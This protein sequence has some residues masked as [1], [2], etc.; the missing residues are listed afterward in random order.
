MTIPRFP[1]IRR[2]RPSALPGGLSLIE[3]TV[4]TLLA[5]TVLVS[6][7]RCV[8]AAVSSRVRTA[9]DVRAA[10]L[11]QQLMSE[12]VAQPYADT[13]DLVRVFGL[14]LS[15]VYAANGPRLAF[16][17]V[18]DY[19]NWNSSPPENPANVPHANLAG[20]RRQVTV[21]WVRPADLSVSTVSDTGLKRITVTVSRNGQVLSRLTALRSEKLVP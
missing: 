5:G 3:V 6:A 12:I 15:E 4:A 19:H 11:T 17:D 14:E 20:W 18:D 10:F 9:D 1:R 7:L 21:E 16:D 13:N 2:L 8:G